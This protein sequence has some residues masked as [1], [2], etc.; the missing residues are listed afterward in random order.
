MA[1]RSVRLV[2]STAADFSLWR[3]L[4][5][6][7]S[8]WTMELGKGNHRIGY[9]GH[10]MGQD[11]QSMQTLSAYCQNQHIHIAGQHANRNL[12]NARSPASVSEVWYQLLHQRDL[13]A[14]LGVCPH[15]PAAWPD[16]SHL[17]FSGFLS[18][19]FPP[20]ACPHN[21]LNTT[22]SAFHDNAEASER[23][24]QRPLF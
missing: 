8:T 4:I 18:E 12:P 16:P 7:A 9:S 21:M 1:M 22:V 10:T 2:L 23:I 5:S 24:F 11:P 20:P 3:S 19:A 17:A 6:C 14:L 15:G 13:P